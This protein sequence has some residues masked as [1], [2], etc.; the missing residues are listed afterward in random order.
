MTRRCKCKR[1]VGA[2]NVFIKQ[3]LHTDTSGGFFSQF[4]IS[5]RIAAFNWMRNQPDNVP[6]RDVDVDREGRSPRVYDGDRSRY[7][8]S[9]GE[10]IFSRA[11][12]KGTEWP[13]DRM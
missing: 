11:Y 2:E 7:M 12:R 9:W 13:N 4:T 8:L 5:R 6:L 10:A 1:I 3:R